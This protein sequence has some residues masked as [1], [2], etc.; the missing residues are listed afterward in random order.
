MLTSCNFWCETLAYTH[1]IGG[2]YHCLNPIDFA[3]QWG[4]SLHFEAPSLAQTQRHFPIPII[5]YAGDNSNDMH[6]GREARQRKGGQNKDDR[7]LQKI[8]PPNCAT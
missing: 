5:C 8:M 1:Y 4:A 7:I 3:L 6:N 2:K